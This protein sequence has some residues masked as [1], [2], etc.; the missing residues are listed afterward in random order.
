MQGSD[1]K[2]C[3]FLDLEQLTKV[4][5]KSGVKTIGRHAFCKCRSL[6][7]IDFPM[8][9]QRIGGYVFWYCHNLH[10]NSLTVTDFGWKVFY[11][12]GKLQSIDIKGGDNLPLA[13]RLSSQYPTTTPN[14]TMGFLVSQYFFHRITALDLFEPVGYDVNKKPQCKEM[15]GES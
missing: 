5:I 8:G 1:P 3:E 7:N 9:L 11:E 15:E 14:I 10:F 12:C 2:G 6:S 4:E 13:I